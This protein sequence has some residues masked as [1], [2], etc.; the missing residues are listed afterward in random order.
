MNQKQFYKSMA[1][2]RARAA[3][4]NHRKSIDGGMCEVCQTEAGRIVHHIVW[5]DDDNCNDPNI[6]LNPM[7][8]RYECQECHNKEKDPRK[9]NA[10]RY[11]FGANGEI[12]RATDY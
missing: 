11:V 5:L 9:A 2:R 6:A 8:F 3:Y 4:I 10:R 1:W 7:N 12:L